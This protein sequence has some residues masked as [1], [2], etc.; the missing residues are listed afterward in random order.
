MTQQSHSEYSVTHWMNRLLYFRSYSALNIHLCLRSQFKEALA[1]CIFIY[2]PTVQLL[3]H[4]VK[5][6][7]DLYW[8][9]EYYVITNKPT[10]WILSTIT[11]LNLLTLVVII[12]YKIILVLFSSFLWFVESLH[13]FA[14]MFFRGLQLKKWYF[15]S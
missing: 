6:V 13:I 8:Y 4:S 3:W 10:V 9:I 15:P 1:Y 12:R 11:T 5:I 14:F 2:T 7:Q